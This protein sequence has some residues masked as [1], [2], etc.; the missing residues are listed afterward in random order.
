MN[1]SISK[2]RSWGSV[3]REAL[4]VLA[5]VLTC[6]YC[7]KEGTKDTGPDGRPWSI[8]HVFPIHFGGSD[9][10]WNLVKACHRCNS[11]K[12]TQTGPEWTPNDDV[13]TAAGLPFGAFF[14]EHREKNP[15]VAQLEAQVKRQKARIREL[16]EYLWDAHQALR[17]I[18]LITTGLGDPRNLLEYNPSVG[19][20][21]E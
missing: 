18:R 6:A 14:A 21:Q 5:D 8:D 2:P 12:H 4:T 9:E 20:G 3:R 15:I 11:R 10:M 7:E 19:G 13:M 1:E 16:E 17:N